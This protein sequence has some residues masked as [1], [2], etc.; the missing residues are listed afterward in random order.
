MSDTNLP[1]GCTSVPHTCDTLPVGTTTYV[2][3]PVVCKTKTWGKCVLYGGVDIGCTYYTGGV[4][5]FTKTG[6]GGSSSSLGPIVVA[7]TGG[8]GTGATFTV[9]QVSSTT[10]I[11]AVAVAGSGYKVGD[12]LTILGTSIS[13]SYAT[14]ANDIVI[15]ITSLSN[16][17]GTVVKEI[18]HEDDFDT[19]IQNLNDRICSSTPSGLNYGT[20]NYGCLRQGGG[21]GTGTAIVTQQQFTESASAA[22]CAINTR[23]LA[24]ETPAV[25]VSSCFSGLITSGT[26]TLVQILNQILAKVCTMNTVF[27]LPITV[28]DIKCFTTAPLSTASV[29]D[30]FQWIVDN[31]CSI[32][33][34]LTTSI[35]TQTTRV[36]NINTYLH[37]TNSPSYPITYDLSCAYIGGSATA[38]VHATLTALITKLCALGATVGGLPT[39]SSISMTWA[40]CFGSAPY[41]YTNTATTLQIQLDRIL[42]VLST[43]K[44]TYSGTD[45][46][47]TG[48]ACGKAISI[49][50]SVLFSCSK[51]STCSI[52]ALS[53][54]DGT[55]TCGQ[56]LTFNGTNYVPVGRDIFELISSGTVDGFDD[57]QLYPGFSI[58]PYVDVTSAS[59]G[60]QR[61]ITTG[62]LE[63]PWQNLSAQVVSPNWSTPVTT[64]TFYGKKTF[65]GNIL[66]RGIISAGSSILGVV[67]QPTGRTIVTG[68][69]SYLCPNVDTILDGSVI[70]KANIS[71]TEWALPGYFKITTGGAIVFFCN[72]VDPAA[73]NTRLSAMGNGTY[74]HYFS[75]YGKAIYQ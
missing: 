24:I 20:F 15:T 56:V 61:T 52:T 67:N 63:Y 64:N 49:N 32:N 3:S 54:V 65:E 33:T 47:V 74:D 19:I 26:S 17:V 68:L 18:F 5:G 53:D 38:N 50:P 7:A 39:L 58:G 57:V 66:F 71:N 34:T 29:G 30:W 35:S 6:I 55:P 43:E 13:G 75:F 70:F 23:V 69:P 40:T 31:T 36:N 25:T 72:A 16:A 4:S 41:S 45:F 59:C 42:N 37:G 27:A 73:V 60:A 1:C 8:F 2:C 10:Y 14:P 28:S 9:S 22:L 46:V 44:A 21:L 62:F 11:V 51:L 48:S 12:V